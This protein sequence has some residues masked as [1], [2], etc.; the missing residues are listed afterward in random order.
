MTMAKERPTTDDSRFFATEHLTT[1]LKRRSVRGGTATLAGQGGRVLLRTVSV[2][3]LARL[4][5]PDAYG[6]IAM[7]TAVTGFV[8]VFKDL[9]LS[10][11]TVQ[12]RAI[13]HTQV[14]TLFW[15]NTGLGLCIALLIAILA[16]AIAW[17]YGEPS[18][19][20]IALGLASTFI[21][22]GLAVQHQAL[23]RR[24]MRFA[25]LAWIEI[26][27]SG[28][29]VVAAIIAAWHGMGYWALVL[30]ELA[31]AG[32]YMIGVWLA[33]GW[34]PGL[35]ERRSDV[36][37]MLGFGANVTGFNIVNYFAR[38]ADNLLIGKF[39]GSNILGLYSRAYALLMLPISQIRG[40]LQAV[41]LP[42]LSRIQDDPKRFERYYAKLV[43]VVAF[44]TMPLTVFL[45]VCARGVVGLLLGDQW[46]A[47]SPIFQVLAIAG[48]IQPVATTKGLVLLSLGQSGRYLKFGLLNSCVVVASFVVGIPWGAIGVAVAYAAVNYLILLPSLWYCYRFTP[49]RISTF[50]RAISRSVLATIAMGFSVLLVYRFLSYQSD[51]FAVGLCFL[52]GLLVYLAVWAMLPGGLQW[53]RDTYAYLLLNLPHRVQRSN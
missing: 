52:N 28:A 6:L 25:A 20:W 24:Q 21:F 41:A 37:A 32:A 36:R 50:F 9:G 15:I 51:A 1:D 29:G 34:R 26:I 8:E 42:A 39:C 33:C 49:I 45:A 27:S 38:N 53:L 46:Q 40:P 12:N 31:T 35:P 7:V 18:L 19:T 43:S 11:A 16:P 14:S 2:A 44:V 22:S 13:N 3:I 4:L 10:I 48:L 17:F 47:V 23:L 5:T 30:M